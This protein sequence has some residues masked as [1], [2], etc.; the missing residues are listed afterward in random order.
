M[1]SINMPAVNLS[2]RH[3]FDIF[4]LYRWHSGF[5]DAYEIFYCAEFCGYKPHM[6]QQ[7]TFLFWVWVFFV[8]DSCM[9]GK[10]FN[11]RYLSSVAFFINIS[12]FHNIRITFF[13]YEIRIFKLQK[14]FTFSY[15]ILNKLLGCC[16][17]H[18]Y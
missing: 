16:L 9:F 3:W 14:P 13:V 11:K 4:R 18:K 12:A 10:S 2:Y 5:N 8:S 17:L 1:E 7:F 6:G 15:P